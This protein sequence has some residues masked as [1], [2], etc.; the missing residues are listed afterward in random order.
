MPG[1]LLIVHYETTTG[2]YKV[3]KAGS[4]QIADLAILSAHI[5]ID[6]IGKE[7]IRDA[8]IVSAALASAL[9]SL[10]GSVS[11]GAI[12]SAKLASGIVG[13]VHLADG[14][15][16]S[17]D[18]AAN[19]I[20][21]PH[22]L[23]GGILS[24]A[25]G[26]D[27]IGKEHIRDANIV[28]AAIAAGI[29]AD[30]LLADYGVVSGKVASGTITENELASGLSIDIAEMVQEPSYRA[31]VL[32]SAATNLG[33]QFSV[34]GYFSYAQARAVTT[35]PAIGITTANILSGQVGTFRYQGRMT[36][37]NWDFSGY[38]GKLLFLGLSSQVTLTA[39]TASGDCVQRVGKVVDA[40]T[41]F[42][43]PELFY[44]QIAE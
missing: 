1:S 14:A 19:I 5:G 12:I 4:A 34:S 41:V 16:K 25:I 15:V 8:N 26:A 40:D 2:T 3:Q 30:A 27:V 39:P 36:N 23:A 32:I 6:E 13:S 10:L 29:I 42:V 28:S 9:V 37:A 22:I 7:H 44:A 20:A 43:R 24:G 18:I 31:Q 35:M 21:T 11:D 38:V 33:V 17:G